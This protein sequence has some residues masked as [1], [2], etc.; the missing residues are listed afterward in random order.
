MEVLM[1]RKL[2]AREVFA[3]PEDIIRERFSAWL[4]K[5]IVIDA[6]FIDSSFQNIIGVAGL[7]YKAPVVL[8][9][10]KDGVV[11]DY[12]KRSMKLYSYLLMVKRNNQL[13]TTALD[14]AGKFTEISIPEKILERVSQVL[15]GVERW[16]GQINEAGEHVIDLR[17]PSPGPHFH[18]NLLIGNRIGYSRPLQTTPKSVIDR[19]GE[20]ASVPM[21]PH[22]CWPRAGIC[23]RRKTD[24]RQTGNFTWLRMTGKFSIPRT[25]MTLISRVPCVRIHKI[26]RGLNT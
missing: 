4:P 8:E 13:Q 11:A 12:L 5:E 6:L 24:F 17:T 26:L 19:L 14:S 9:L 3:T 21:L 10:L 20:E 7:P 1:Y 16:A 15:N 22:R 23:G 25:R 18:T 2:I